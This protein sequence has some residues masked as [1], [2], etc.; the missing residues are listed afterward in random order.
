[1]NR[2]SI[3]LIFFVFAAASSLFFQNWGWVDGV[4]DIAMGSPSL[5]LSFGPYGTTALG[6]P[7]KTTPTTIEGD[8]QNVS[9]ILCIAGLRF[10]EE[11]NEFKDIAFAKRQ[12]ALVPLGTDLDFI[13]VPSAIYHRVTLDLIGSKCNS[14]SAIVSNAYGQFRTQENIKLELIGHR[15]IKHSSQELSL[16][17]EALIEAMATVR[18]SDEIKEKIESTFGEI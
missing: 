8:L 12:V 18:S 5:H 16:K 3:I 4:I 14:A 10:E 15:Q 7:G 2:K 9:L 11:E 1:M 6:K 17:I 13:S